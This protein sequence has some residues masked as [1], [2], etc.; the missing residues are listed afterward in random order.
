MTKKKLPVQPS[1]PGMEDPVTTTNAV[2]H[3]AHYNSGKFEVVEVLED[4]G[5]GPHEFNVIKYV[6]RA[7]K[8][9]P[10]KHIEDL[11]KGAWYLARKIEL[12]K[13]AKEGRPVVRPNDMN[14]RVPTIPQAQ[15]KDF[16]IL[17]GEWVRVELTDDNEKSQ[18]V[19]AFIPAHQHLPYA[20]TLQEGKK[21]SMGFI[22]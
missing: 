7:G 10:A 17:G 15:E 1:F 3:P 4:W 12:M 2:N 9:D 13:A 14:P 22:G 11:E 20:S 18:I 19:W 8:K 16:M 21:C 5:M 6:A